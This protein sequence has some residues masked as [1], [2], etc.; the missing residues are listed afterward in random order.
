[1]AEEI[2][3]LVG[4]RLTSHSRKKDADTISADDSMEE[5]KALA[6]SAGARVAETS[7]QARPKP[8][9][10]TLIGSGKL[11]ELKAQIQFHDATTVIFDHELSPTQQR[12]LEKELDVKV[13]DRTQLILDIFARR[14]RTREGQL[15]VEL[16]QLNYLLPRLTGHGAAMSRLGGG[17]G[18]RG[19][20]ARKR[21]LWEEGQHCLRHCQSPEG[22]QR[23]EYADVVGFEKGLRGC[24]GRCRD[25][26]RHSDGCRRQGFYRR[27]RHQ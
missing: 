17:I 18:T 21:P 24:P 12:N 20:G 2:A 16:A 7:I 23:S 13:L 10:A 8:D 27:R 4:L 26:R 15:Q 5:L 14:A 1:L 6:F 3:I 25:T 9:A 22:A 11:E 19:P